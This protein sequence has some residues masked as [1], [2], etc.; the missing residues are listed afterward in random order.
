MAKEE[1]PVA[2]WDERDEVLRNRYAEAFDAGLTCEQSI[3]FACSTSD[4]GVLRQIVKD[5]CPP[6]LI[7]QIVL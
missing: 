5:G 3:Q 4:I 1:T 6:G 7:A 2:A